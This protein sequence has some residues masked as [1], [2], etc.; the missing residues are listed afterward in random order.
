MNI[1]GKRFKI[2]IGGIHITVKKIGGGGC[3]GGGGSMNEKME[4]EAMW[5]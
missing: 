1:Q 5:I 4:K 3:G 2:C